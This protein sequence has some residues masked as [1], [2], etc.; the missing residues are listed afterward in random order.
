VKAGGHP[1]VL[2]E[3]FCLEGRFDLAGSFPSPGLVAV[4]FDLRR[5]LWLHVVVFVV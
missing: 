2:D 4:V 5:S 1:D 3:L